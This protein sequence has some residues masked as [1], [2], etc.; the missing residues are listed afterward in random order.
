MTFR[1]PLGRIAVVCLVLGM[2]A[3]LTPALGQELAQHDREILEALLGQ[4]VIGDTVAAPPLAASLAALH[5]GTWTYRI[6]GGEGKGGTERNVVE[7][8]TRVPSGASWRYAVGDHYSYF[9]T[10]SD[11]G[12][13]GVLSEH[14]AEQGVITRFDP[15][16]PLLVPGLRAGESKDYQVDVEVYD[17]SHPEHETH[18][19]SL[20]VTYSYL[21]AFEVT[22]PA[23]SHD[24]ALVKWEY[25]GKVGPAT[26]DDTQYRFVAD[27]IG[28]VASIDRE[29]ISALLIYHHDS[30]VGKVLA[31]AP[32]R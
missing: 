14:D 13:L 21:G 7:Q 15:P 1:E 12:G 9:L 27:R 19:G 8:L 22:T 26:V 24:A 6:V 28:M 11:D 16:E 25:A 32:P 23:G 10:R 3:D 17:L 30:K 20:K 5:D 31:E 18:S 4:G 29:H 2:S